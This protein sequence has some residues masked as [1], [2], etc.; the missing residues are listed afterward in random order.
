[1]AVRKKKT[2]RWT[3]A[4]LSDALDSTDAFPGACTA[5]QNLIFDQGNPHSVVSRPGVKLLTA[6][7]GFTNPGFVSLHITIGT[8]IYGFVASQLF[9]GK[10]Q[11]FSF[12]TV[13]KTFDTMT[14]ITA[15]SLPLSA[16]TTGPWTPPTAA[17]I[18]ATIIFTHPGFSSSQTTGVMNIASPLAPTWATGNLTVNPLPGVPTSVANFNNRAYYTI[19]NIAYFSDPLNPTVRTNASQS[20][21]LG[22]PS[23]IL[24]QVGLPVTTSSAGIIPALL[25]FK[26]SEIWQV[27]GDAATPAN[28][29]AQT[30]LSLNE[31]TSSPR[32][33]AQT[34]RGIFFIGTD[35]PMMIDPLG[36]VRAL[37]GESREVSDVR[38]PFLNTTE[39]TRIASAYVANIYRVCVPTFIDGT[40]AIGDYW[41]DFHRQR[42]NGPHNFTYDCASAIGNYTILS[43]NDQPGK[44]YIGEV[45][46]NSSSIY[47]DDDTGLPVE[48]NESDGLCVIRSA[49]FPYPGD[50]LEY[51]IVESSIEFS[52]QGASVDYTVTMSDIQHNP[53]DTVQVFSPQGGSIWGGFVWGDGTLYAPSSKAPIIFIIPWKNPLV[54][55][56]FVLSVQAVSSSALL[57]GAFNA[58]ANPTGYNARS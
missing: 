28:P 29:L 39:P 9:T 31:G 47:E 21:T 35:G 27:I 37:T 45:N 11:P 46:Q 24:A 17:V 49:A 22:D 33:I 3:P 16:P 38:Q 42:W 13:T 19:G 15:A 1:M 30:F 32:S 20:L 48:T 14:G 51:Q 5:L 2:F 57:V 6:F 58:T 50:M 36:N 18:G 25:L 4:G 56:K 43:G 52:V 26:A 44:L 41:F 54:S 12:N 8:R 34:N 53:L 10:D 40:Q 55:S 23:P 7:A